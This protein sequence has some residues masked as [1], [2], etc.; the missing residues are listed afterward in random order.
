MIEIKNGFSI[1]RAEKYRKWYGNMTL[2]VNWENDGFEIVNF[3]DDK[4][5]QRSR[6]QNIRYYL[7]EGFTWTALT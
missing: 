2:V 3:R 6:P 4:G 5:K 1:I 7:Q